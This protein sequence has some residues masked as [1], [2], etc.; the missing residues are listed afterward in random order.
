MRQPWCV[1]DLLGAPAED[2]GFVSWSRGQLFRVIAI[3]GRRYEVKYSSWPYRLYALCSDDFSAEEKQT[4]AEEALQTTRC[5]RD[6]FT[7]GFCLRFHTVERM[8]SH[9]A[10]STLR[11]TFENVRLST[12]LSERLHAEVTA[13]KPA[14]GNARDFSHFSRETLLKQ[15]RVV[16]MQRGGSDP[17]KPSHLLAGTHPCTA[18]VSP[19]LDIPAVSVSAP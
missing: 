3:V 7:Q 14:R 1:L 19:L 6:I 15:S 11:A 18:M 4:I 5:C 12:D 8:L 10:R 17:L 9:E 16:H 2:Q 13:S